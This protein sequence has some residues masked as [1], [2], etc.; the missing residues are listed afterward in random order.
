M[1]FW[2]PSALVA[3]VSFAFT[4]A[5]ALVGRQA[6]NRLRFRDE[7]LFELSGCSAY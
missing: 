5:K 7:Q 3:Q 4:T 2:E 1:V 6:A